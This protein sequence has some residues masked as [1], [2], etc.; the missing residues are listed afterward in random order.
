MTYCDHV[1]EC[2]V[3]LADKR[4][5]VSDHQEQ[6]HANTPHVH[7]VGVAVAKQG[8]RS[9]T[10]HLMPPEVLGVTQVV[11]AAVHHSHRE[12]CYLHDEAIVGLL[13]HDISGSKVS[14]NDV[15]AVAVLSGF[16]NCLQ[17]A[18]SVVQ[19]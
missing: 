9:H 5:S 2:C 6:Q 19:R 14:Y 1:H 11:G 7:L 3:V 16:N 18:S 15:F 4:H 17:Y 8:L 10:A 13:A 12:V